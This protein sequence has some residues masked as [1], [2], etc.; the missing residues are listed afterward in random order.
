[1]GKKVLCGGFAQCL[2][3][4]FAVGDEENNLILYNVLT[5]KPISVLTTATNNN[6]PSALTALAFTP[7]D[8]QIIVG[9]SRGSINIWDLSTLKSNPSVTQSTPRSR[10]TPLRYQ[11]W[12]ATVPLTTCLSAAL[13]ILL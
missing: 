13:L 8:D 5:P 10:D 11:P 1:M 2:K 7:N 3:N 9:S 12:L 6:N 4:N